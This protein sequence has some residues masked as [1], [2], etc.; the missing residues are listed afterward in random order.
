MAVV[1]AR[2]EHA[3]KHMKWTPTPNKPPPSPQGEIVR[4]FDGKWTEENPGAAPPYKLWTATIATWRVPRA[5]GVPGHDPETADGACCCL[6][7][8]LIVHLPRAM[9]EFALTL[10]DPKEDP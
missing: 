1:L 4:S 3:L 9:A 10:A 2:V 7:E 6:T 5:P 8:G